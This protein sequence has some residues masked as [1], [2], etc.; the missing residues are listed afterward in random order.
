MMADEASTLQRLGYFG[1]WNTTTGQ[2]GS[3]PVKLGIIGYDTP[4]WT[5]PLRQ[6]ML[7]ALARLGHPVADADIQLIQY[8]TDN[9]QI[10][11]AVAQIQAAVLKFRQDRVSHVIVLDAN[12]SMMLQ[13]LQNARG[14]RYFPRF[15]IN[16]ATGVEALSTTGAVSTKQ[17]NGAVGLGWAPTLDLPT[18][19]ADRYLGPSTKACIKMV[20]RRTGQR[21]TST[22]A[23][24]IALSHC[25][26]LYLLRAVLNSAGPVLNQQTGRAALEALGS[27]F[28]PAE[29]AATFFSPTRHDGL[30]RGYDMVWNNGCSCVRYVGQ[31]NIP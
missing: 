3:L 30:E 11:P 20:E 15:G 17:F 2:A 22:N 24:S 21:F 29:I 19:Q 16:T 14:Q 9:S 13:L 5:R 10:A 8:P 28:Q 12:G 7:P 4:T 1:G 27:R 26:G 18:G 25:D 6:V 31:H 23:A